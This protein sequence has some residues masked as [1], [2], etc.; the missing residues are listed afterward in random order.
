MSFLASYVENIM[1]SYGFLD[2]CKLF[3]GKPE[4]IEDTHQLPLSSKPERWR[5]V[6]LPQSFS[7]TGVSVS[8][9]DLDLLP[10]REPR[11]DDAI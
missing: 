10:D 9:K 11:D 1:Y 6:P 7:R 8:K 2:S 4:T 5:H 3:F